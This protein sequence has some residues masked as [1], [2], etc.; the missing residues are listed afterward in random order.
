MMVRTRTVLLV[1]A[2]CITNAILWF[3]LG[4]LSL[5]NLMDHQTLPVSIMGIISV[6]MFGNAGAFLLVVFGL[7]RSS[8]WFYVPTLLLVMVNL[9]TSLT[10]QMGF[11]DWF[12]LGLNLVLFGLLVSARKEFIRGRMF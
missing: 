12:V 2:L 9:V 8:R 5:S 1:Q 6:L 11:L 3:V 4:V 10:D 7:R